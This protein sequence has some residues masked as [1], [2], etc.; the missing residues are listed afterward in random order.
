MAKKTNA[1]ALTAEHKAMAAS[2][3]IDLSK[4]PWGR[5]LQVIQLVIT[6][7]QSQPQ[8]MTAAAQDGCEDHCEKCLDAAALA[9]QSAHT[10]LDCACGMCETPAA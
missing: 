4:V 6:I 3:G 8:Q 5:L 2:L 1:P 9:L 7:L 10:S